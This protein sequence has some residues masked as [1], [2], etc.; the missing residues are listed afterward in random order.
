M[1]ST[2]RASSGGALPNDIGNLVVFLASDGASFITGQLDPDRRRLGDAL[3]IEEIAR[4]NLW[5]SDFTGTGVAPT[6]WGGLEQVAGVRL[7]TL[8]DG[9][10]RGV[11]VLEFRTGSGF[12]FDVLVDRAFDIGRCEYR[13]QGDRLA[14]GVGYGGPWFRRA[15]LGSAGCG[16]GAAGC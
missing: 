10:E 15:D 7:V 4:L 8:G 12:A 11:R 1:C 6:R 5:G 3:M 9:R 16:T 2:A 14:V 13:R